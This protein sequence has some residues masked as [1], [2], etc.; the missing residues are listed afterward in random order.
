MPVHRLSSRAALQVQLR[1]FILSRETSDVRVHARLDMRSVPSMAS[2]VSAFTGSMVSHASSTRLFLPK[3]ETPRVQDIFSLQRR[4]APTTMPMP[5]Q[6]QTSL[7]D[8]HSPIV[9]S[10]SYCCLISCYLIGIQ[11]CC[12]DAVLRTEKMCSIPRRGLRSIFDADA[13]LH[14]IVS[15]V[16]YN[17]DGSSRQRQEQYSRRYRTVVFAHESDKEQKCNGETGCR[18][19]QTGRVVLPGWCIS[20]RQFFA[21]RRK[22]LN[23]GV[24][25]VRAI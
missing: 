2:A 9:T 15:D 14:V 13:R 10:L 7:E 21:L 24:I 20:R 19:D 11:R 3:K 16:I 12:V 5:M 25:T 1:H 8:I 18:F 4:L 23:L 22:Q 6:P 17:H